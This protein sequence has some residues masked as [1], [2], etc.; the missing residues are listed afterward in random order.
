MAD[1]SRSLRHLTLRQ[2]R[3]L[4]V[5]ARQLNLSAAARELHLTQPAVSGQLRELEA[6]CGLPL[7]ERDGRGIR[8]TEAGEELAGC[9]AAVLDQ[10]RISQE[11]LDAMRG[12]R[13]GVLRLGAVSTAKYF[14][15]SMLAEFTALHPD[16]SVEFAVG[17]RAEM[18]TR[19]ARGD[20]DLVIMGRPPPEL[21][22]EGVAF[23]EHPLVI[24]AAPAHPLAAAR[25]SKARITL[26]ELKHEN[27]L[28]RERGSGT[29]AT[30]EALFE[31]PQL[32][33]R[34][35]MEMSSNETIK[36]AVMAGMGISLI[37]LH[38]VALE[39]QTGRL[40]ML[41]V[42]D[43]PVIRTWYSLWLAGRR[44]SPLASAFHDYLQAHGAACIARAVGPVPA[45]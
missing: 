23:A 31:R 14:A 26:R 30:M 20:S 44:L 43:T 38:T 6:C 22:T 7:Y 42:E 29:R 10:L 1:I 35:G 41:P 37:S 32:G 4:R 3:T 17:N 21:E 11:R 18:I 36:Q 45:P 25:A 8:L 13:T 40:V 12:L 9:A 39:I 5:V 15:P 24:I 34:A 16:V 27:F 28:V 33:Y 19:L 2:L